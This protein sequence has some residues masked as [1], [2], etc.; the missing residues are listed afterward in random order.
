[1]HILA[2]RCDH[3]HW[4]AGDADVEEGHG[5]AIDDPQANALTR[6]E[7]IFQPLFWPASIGEIGIGWRADIGDVSCHHAHLRPHA[8]FGP[9]H[10]IAVSPARQLSAEIAFARAQPAHN[11]MRVQRGKFTQ[12]ENIVP[13]IGHRLGAC[14][15]NNQRPI[16]ARLFLH[17]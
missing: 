8:P 3:R 1:M 17:A 13:V 11:E 4:Q 5:R 14:G 9:G 12:Q 2:I 10:R 16:M 7:Q 6:A 15:I